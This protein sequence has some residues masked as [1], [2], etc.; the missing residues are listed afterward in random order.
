MAKPSK[1]NKY[2][3]LFRKPG[4]DIIHYKKK[5]PSLD[6]PLQGSTHTTDWDVAILVLKAICD[7]WALQSVGISTIKTLGEL[8]ED[9]YTTMDGS[10]SKRYREDLKLTMEVNFGMLF[11]K[12]LGYFKTAVVRTLRNIYLNRLVRGVN[13][14][15]KKCSKGGANTTFRQLKTI[16]LYAVE[17]EYISSVPYRLKR[18]RKKRHRRPFVRMSQLSSYLGAVDRVGRGK[19]SPLAIRLMLGLGLRLSEVRAARWEWIDWDVKTYTP[20]G[21]KSGGDVG[22]PI[23]EWLLEYLRLANPTKAPGP[24]IIGRTLK[25]CAEEERNKNFNPRTTV[26]KAGLLIEVPGLTNHRLRG[27][28]A[29]LLGRS[30]VPLSVI[31][32]LMR[33]EDAN[34]TNLYME[35][36]LDRLE[37]AT[38]RFQTK[39]NEV[40]PGVDLLRPVFLTDDPKEVDPDDEEEGD[41]G[42]EDEEEEEEDDDGESEDE[43]EFD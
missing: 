24:M 3:C 17:M 16:F 26:K 42:D 18:L 2:K 4:S 15:G 27:T 13:L 35:K 8:V 19:G 7:Q 38:I 10:V 21:A 34:T 12:P 40:C 22:L 36:D 39:L 31:Q 6:K 25:P 41:A 9:W 30:N 20:D 33:H 11:D 1:R 29:T 43:E 5:L 28:F 23:M 32:M 14:S 37:E